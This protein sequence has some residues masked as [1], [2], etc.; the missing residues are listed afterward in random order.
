M[1]TEEGKTKV[2]KC[3]AGGIPSAYGR[4]KGERDD[5]LQARVDLQD[6]FGQVSATELSGWIGG[7]CQDGRETVLWVAA[8]VMDAES[9]MRIALLV[10]HTGLQE[11][12]AQSLGAKQKELD[13][14]SAGAAETADTLKHARCVN[15]QLRDRVNEYDQE[16]RK[17][18]GFQGT[19]ML[20]A[21]EFRQERDEARGEV[22]RL[23]ARC[24]DLIEE[25][26][27]ARKEFADYRTEVADAQA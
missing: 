6:V 14:V 20:D 24:F 18:R 3:R 10:T 11:Q 22:A 16:C 17:L 12:H 1:L 26:E 25:L 21:C 13:G 5:G 7:L 23:K 15:D 2:L 9:F 19:A 4:T 27:F 8:N